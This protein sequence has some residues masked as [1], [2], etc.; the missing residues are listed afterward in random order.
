MT[1]NLIDVRI[2]SI[3]EEIYHLRTDEVTGGIRDMV[4]CIN[5]HDDLTYDVDYYAESGPKYYA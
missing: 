4:K 3:L 5:I 2:D 1:E